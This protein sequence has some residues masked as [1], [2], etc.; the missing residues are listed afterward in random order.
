MREPSDTRRRIQEIALDLFT[1]RGYEATSL[2]EIAE[3]LGVTKAALYYHFKTKDDIVTSL[4]EDRIDALEALV[5]WGRERQP[6]TAEGRE[7]LIRRYAEEMRAGQHHKVMH[8]LERNQAALRNSPKPEHARD[9]IVAMIDLISPPDADLTTRLRHAMG[10]FALHAAWFL[11][12][13]EKY[14]DEER[15]TAALEVALDLAGAR[16]AGT[17]VPVSGGSTA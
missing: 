16:P 17:P 12:P 8:L 13:D 11:V 7:T 6:L 4:L 5:E 15:R 1:E 2:R 3:E 9:L 10:L 14:S